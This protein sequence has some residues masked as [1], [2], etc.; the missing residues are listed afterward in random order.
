MDFIELFPKFKSYYSEKSQHRQQLSNEFAIKLEGEFKNKPLHKSSILKMI[1]LGG[2]KT[3][4]MVDN[5]TPCRH[6]NK[7]LLNGVLQNK[8]NIENNGI[9]QNSRRYNRVQ[10]RLLQ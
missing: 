6:S 2:K 3:L 5:K 4:G 10:S 7:A 8:L 1:S 9:L